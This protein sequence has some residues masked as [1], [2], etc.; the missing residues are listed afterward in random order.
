ME[1]PRAGYLVI[2]RANHNAFLAEDGKLESAIKRYVDL[3]PRFAAQPIALMNVEIVRNYRLF[4]K[5]LERFGEPGP[6]GMVQLS[7]LT[8]LSMRVLHEWLE[9]G[10]IEADGLDPQQTAMN[11]NEARFSAWNGFVCWVA[12]FLH[13]SGC[14]R[15]TLLVATRTLRG[16][17][18][19]GEQQK[20]ASPSLALPEE[21]PPADDQ[22]SS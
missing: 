8:K 20:L 7:E 12:S 22:S 6:L 18:W 1:K 2:D 4:Q 3:A 17:H 10:I 13:S 19:L 14:H 21:F 9:E 5:H 15:Q 11:P 16:Q